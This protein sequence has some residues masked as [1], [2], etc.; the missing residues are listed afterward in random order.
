MNRGWSVGVVG[1]VGTL[2]SVAA[3]A[4]LRARVVADLDA[5]VAMSDVTLATVGERIFYDV[6]L[7]DP[8]GTSCASCHDPAHGFAG[9]HGSTNGV[10]LGSRPGHFARRN[11]PSVLYLGLV[12]RFHFHWEEDA[13]LPDAVGG[14]FWDGR[15]DSL[16]ELTRQPLLNEDEMGNH[17][18]AALARTIATRPYATDLAHLA[19]PLV[20]PEATLAA[21]GK[22]AEAFLLSDAMS[23]FTSKY[24]D[25]VRGKATLTEREARG[26]SLFKDPAKGNCVTCHKMNDS[27]PDPARSPFSDFGFEAV[28][29]PRNAQLPANRDT[30]SFDLGLCEHDGA[31]GQTRD[32]RFCG[33]FRTPSLRNVALRP[34]FM[35]NG[36]FSRLRDVVAFY[37]TRATDPRRWY[38][39][40][41]YDD[42]PARYRENVNDVVAPYDR[43][44]GGAP[45]LDD[46]EIDSI[47]AFLETLT[48]APHH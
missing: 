16:A 39:A 21:V 30:E 34:S 18:V 12:H 10:A 11:T 38:G 22:A 26:L 42:L 1:L 35:H 46:D 31:G 47:V 40:V 33:A 41:T 19:G 9:S 37:A 25:F 20:D 45:A 5:P 15:T 23:P 3:F 43:H 29:V 7:S 2:A 13:P 17:D 27:V 36:A 24:D 48:D 32:P 44:E 4:S 14:F 6:A 28:G 8:P